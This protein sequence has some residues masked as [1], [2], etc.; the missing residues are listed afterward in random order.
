MSSTIIL[1]GTF[2][3]FLIWTMWFNDNMFHI[4]T[5]T[6]PTKVW[7]I[8]TIRYCDPLF[9]FGKCHPRRKVTVLKSIFV[10]LKGKGE[11]W[12]INSSFVWNL[13]HF[14][15]P[16]KV[17]CFPST[18]KSYLGCKISII[19]QPDNLLV[20]LIRICVKYLKIKN[21]LGWNESQHFLWHESCFLRLKSQN[22]SP[23]LLRKAL[24]KNS[25]LWLNRGRG[26]D[27]LVSLSK[28]KGGIWTQFSCP[29]MP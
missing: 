23:Y 1:K 16:I 5:F 2:F 11:R 24:K 12:C 10:D 15:Q 22:F 14:K 4:D 17:H 27:W 25:K 21:V 13:K 9:I 8:H 20:V 29:N 7:A 28:A 26:S 3:S 19:I 6:V 18:G